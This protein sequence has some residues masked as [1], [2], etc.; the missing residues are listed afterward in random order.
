MDAR[1]GEAL[2]TRENERGA[3]DG[4]H[5]DPERAAGRNTGHTRCKGC[6]AYLNKAFTVKK[7]GKRYCWT[8]S[9]Y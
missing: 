7:K 5:G 8:C 2:A 6:G 3:R 1:H 4:A 9:A